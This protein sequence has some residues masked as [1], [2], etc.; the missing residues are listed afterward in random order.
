MHELLFIYD[1]VLTRAFE[2]GCLLL[3]SGFMVELTSAMGKPMRVPR[4]FPFSTIFSFLECSF[5][6]SFPYGQIR[7]YVCTHG[8]DAPCAPSS[9]GGWLGAG[10][11][12]GRILYDAK[13]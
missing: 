12:E 7:A 11:W 4:Q 3:V 6:W 13:G 9:S 5:R 2:K 10:A 8:F 1:A